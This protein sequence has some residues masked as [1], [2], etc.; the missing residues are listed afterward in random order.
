MKLL[1]DKIQYDYIKDK[2]FSKTLVSVI[3]GYNVFL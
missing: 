2:N 3:K 1:M